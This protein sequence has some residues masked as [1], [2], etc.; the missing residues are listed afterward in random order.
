MRLTVRGL[1]F[2]YPSVP[3]LED[4]D[5]VLPEGEVLAI[6]GRNGAGKSTLIKCLNRI[7]EPRQG[8]VLLG[9]REVRTMGRKEVARNMAYLSQK[10]TYAFPITVFDAVLLGRHPHLTWR[11]GPHDEAKVAEIL[12]A[13]NLEPLAL[14]DVDEISGGEQQKVL[15]ARALAQEA[16]VL[17]LDEPTS[18]LDIR[19]QLEV[20]ALIRQFAK[21]KGLSAIVVVHDL[22]LASRYAD[23]VVMLKDGRIYASGRPAEVLTP[24]HIAEV[25]G[26]VAEVRTNGGAPSIVPLRAL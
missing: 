18:N 8:S 15:I 20:M 2:E 6:V 23:R 26:V 22:N 13:L 14:R 19:H 17:L 10:S 3:V 11:S 5:L 24:E 1:A 9:D 25:Y 12:Q 21:D 4:V 7:L 16:G